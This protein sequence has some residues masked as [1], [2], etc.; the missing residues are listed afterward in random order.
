VNRLELLSRLAGELKKIEG[1]K[2]VEEAEGYYPGV[3]AYLKMVIEPMSLDVA[4]QVSD[5]IAEIQVEYLEE[6]GKMPVVE[7][8]IIGKESSERQAYFEAKEVS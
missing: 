5:R 1:V 7:W 4:E 6:T 3:D 2:E 8:D